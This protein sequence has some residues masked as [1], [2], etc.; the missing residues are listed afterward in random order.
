[1]Q[2]RLDKRE[3]G[4]E[5]TKAA[6][7]KLAEDGYD[8]LYGA[9]PLKRLIQREVVDRIAKAVLEGRFTKGDVV[10]ID[11]K[12]DGLCIE[13]GANREATQPRATA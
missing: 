8:P 2:Q 10:K 4:L 11:V 12:D 1:M 13:P 7:A 5:V 9:R 6:K 3:L